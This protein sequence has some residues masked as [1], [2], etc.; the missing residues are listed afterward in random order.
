MVISGSLLVTKLQSSTP[1][2]AGAFSSLARMG[3][4]FAREVFTHSQL[5]G[6]PA[7]KHESLNYTNSDEPKISQYLP[8]LP[9]FP[10][11]HPKSATSNTQETSTAYTLKSRIAPLP[12]KIEFI[13]KILLLL[14]ALWE[15]V[16]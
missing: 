9:K 15:D 13:C 1:L 7:R 11:M 10:K 8:L 6:R 12:A 3:E 14:V 4:Q 16:G 2:L 5:N